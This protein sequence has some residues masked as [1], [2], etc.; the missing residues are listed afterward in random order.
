[1]R[2]VLRVVLVWLMVVALPVQGF[3]VAAMLHCGPA[4]GPVSLAAEAARA[5][6]TGAAAGQ[7]PHHQANATG[8]AAAPAHAHAHA[9]PH[10]DAA[11]A[12]V[13]ADAHSPHVAAG[14]PTTGDHQ[15]SVCAAC[16][17]ALALPAAVVKLQPM[18][19]DATFSRPALPALPSFVPAGLDRPPRPILA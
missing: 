18:R 14:D 13:P 15:C 4:Q 9:G 2:F 5:V 1:M 10:A 7:A 11:A 6:E 8:A 3:S 12:D 17:L 19:V 16:C